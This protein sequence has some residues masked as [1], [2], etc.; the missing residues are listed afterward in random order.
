MQIQVP[1]LTRVPV[2]TL[3]ATVGNYNSDKPLPCTQAAAELFSRIT[4]CDLKKDKELQ[5]I[6]KRLAQFPPTVENPGI[7]LL[8]KAFASLEKSDSLSAKIVGFENTIPR[9]E[10]NAAANELVRRAIAAPSD[11]D[12]I[13]YMSTIEQLPE[14]VL[15]TGKKIVEEHILQ[16]YKVSELISVISNPDAHGIVKR[17]AASREFLR[18]C[19]ELENQREELLAGKQSLLDIHPQIEVPHMDQILAFGKAIE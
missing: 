16:S 18:R 6:Q 2:T 7:D 14:D 12:L 4:T 9:R 5:K 15:N 1:D 13:I 3:F 10:L 8:F 19:E 11:P 17:T